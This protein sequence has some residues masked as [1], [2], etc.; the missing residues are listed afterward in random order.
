MVETFQTMGGVSLC[1][2]AWQMSFLTALV[3]ISL[4][5]GRIQVGLVVIYI[6][7]LYWGVS[8]YWPEFITAEGIPGALALYLTCGLALVFL[9]LLSFFYPAILK[10][11]WPPPAE[12]T[13]G[14]NVSI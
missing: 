8:L 10:R 3:T 4:L 2:P 9:G 6:F 5:F 1:I 14:E 12:Q 11:N 13:A 7:V